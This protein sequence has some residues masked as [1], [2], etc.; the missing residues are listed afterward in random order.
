MPAY[1]IENKVTK[2]REDVFLSWEK[3]KTLLT[4]LGD[5]WHQVPVSASFITG[6]KGVHSLTSD[7]FRDVL[8][9]I[10]KANRGSNIYVK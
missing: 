9:G 10:K 1:T 4:E 7:G 5:D 8:R 3:L 2:E 6:A